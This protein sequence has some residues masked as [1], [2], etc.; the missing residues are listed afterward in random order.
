VTRRAA[1]WR[2][3][4]AVRTAMRSRRSKSFRAGRCRTRSRGGPGRG[5]RSA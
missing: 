4:S 1:V 2:S 3:A 5:S